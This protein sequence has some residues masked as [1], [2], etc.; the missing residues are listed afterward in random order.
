MSAGV[1]YLDY[2]GEIDLLLY[3]VGKVCLAHRDPLR[4]YLG[5]IVHIIKVNRKLQHN[6][7][8]T[9]NNP[10]PSGTRRIKNYN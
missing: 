7:I 5:I 6:S 1:F 9:T 10:D 8:R 4:V 3:N 2:Q